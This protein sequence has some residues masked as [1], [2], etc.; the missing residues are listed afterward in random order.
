M[1]S[2]ILIFRHGSSLPT[3][4]IQCATPGYRSPGALGRADTLCQLPQLASGASDDSHLSSFLLFPDDSR[5]DSD[6]DPDY[7]PFSDSDDEIPASVD[8]M[9][10]GGHDGQVS[11]YPG[12]RL[13]TPDVSEGREA[14]SDTPDA[15]QVRIAHTSRSGQVDPQIRSMATEGF[16][17]AC[18]SNTKGRR[19]WDRRNVCSFCDRPQAKI[20]RHLQ[21]AHKTEIDVQLAL[22]HPVRSMERRKALRALVKEGNYRHNL[23]VRSGEKK[24]ELI[25]C[26]RARKAR[27]GDDYL[28]CDSCKGFFVRS[29]LWRHKRSCNPTE[30]GGRVQA[31]ARRAMPPDSTVSPKMRKVIDSMNRDAVSL[32]S[33]TDKTI[34]LFGE[35]LCAKLGLEHKDIQNIRNRMREL[36]RLLQALQKHRPEAELKYYLKPKAFS[37]LTSCVR[38]VCGFSENTN[39]YQTP[40]LALKLGH[41]LKGCAELVLAR[42]LEDASDASETR[43]FL[44]L[45]AL[46]WGKK[47]SRHALGTLAEAKWN[48]C[49]TM[50][51]AADIQKMH[52]FLETETKQ[53]SQNL[54]ENP[55]PQ[56]FKKLAELVL[57]SVIMFNRRRQGEASLITVDAYRK[58]TSDAVD[59]PEVTEALSQFERRLANSLTRVVVRGKKG[60]GVPVLFTESMR[61]S[62]D[63]LLQMREAAGVLE[64]PYLFANSISADQRPLKGCD[65]LRKLALESGVNNPSAVTSTKLRKHIATMSQLVNLKDNE[66]DLLASFLGHDVRVHREVYRMPEAT[67]QLAL[68]S[69]LLIASE[70]GLGKWRGKSLAEIEMCDIPDVESESDTELTTPQC[71]STG[72]GSQESAGPSS[73]ESA[74]PSSQES[75][76]PSAQKS[77]RHEHE[78]EDEAEEPP[79]KRGRKGAVRRP[80]TQDERDAVQRHLGVFLKRLLVPGKAQCEKILKTERALSQRSW[81]D[82]KNYVHNQVQKRRKL[83]R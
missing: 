25:A 22:M 79:R 32:I 36:G 68:V 51:I 17:V 46:Q 44:E 19:K 66:L 27:T 9:D 77:K 71:S 43:Q 38:E 49:D 15:V 21:R 41:S 29:T 72:P 69:K 7:N 28:A 31:R 16:A 78:S 75:A 11:R 3:T 61:E 2:W 63:L 82:L 18:T 26:N 62:V 33:R 34:V 5:G 8:T 67:T 81:R 30:S 70:K 48:K 73:Q 56:N 60:R 52:G 14:R 6:R 4:Y 74:G 12:F 83:G 53:S 39:K 24:G 40:S 59:N 64:S 45:Y 76:G 1:G 20:G 80:W 57:T 47:V 23:A 65:C 55:S 42:E 13:T 35:S 37:E 10:I 58:A 50:P 54:K